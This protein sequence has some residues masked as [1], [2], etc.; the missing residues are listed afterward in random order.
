ML[1]IKITGKELSASRVV[2]RTTIT[3]EEIREELETLGYSELAEKESVETFQQKSYWY[4]SDPDKT[5][6][7][8]LLV[9]DFTGVG[10]EPDLYIYSD[11]DRWLPINVEDV[12]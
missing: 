9:E 8:L 2:A 5:G 1:P 6:I 10:K 3:S 4:S 11:R 12:A 7:Q